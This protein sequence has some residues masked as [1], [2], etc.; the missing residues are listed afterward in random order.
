MSF[1]TKILGLSVLGIVL[2]G[3]ILVSVVL[4]EKGQ[5]REQITTEVDHLDARSVRRS[6]KTST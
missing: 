4:L 2:T 3:A 5:L 1:K 6:P